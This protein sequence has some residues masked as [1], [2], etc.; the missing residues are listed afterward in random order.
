[1]KSIYIRMSIISEKAVCSFK[2]DM[3]GLFWKIINNNYENMKLIFCFLAELQKI[4]ASLPY[5]QH[6][7]KI[8][9]VHT[10]QQ[11]L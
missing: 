10:L 11:A 7:A 1:M 5:S 4:F 8:L 6:I 3:E 2:Q 9:K